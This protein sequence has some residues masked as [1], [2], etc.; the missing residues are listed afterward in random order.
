MSGLG[1]VFILLSLL[2]LLDL[3]F[4]RSRKTSQKNSKNATQAQPKIGEDLLA[5]LMTIKAVSKVKI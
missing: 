2:G 5:L 1:I 3:Q 4:V